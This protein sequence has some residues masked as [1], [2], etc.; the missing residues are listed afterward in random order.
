MHGSSALGKA[1]PAR[2][3]RAAVAI[4]FTL[5]ACFLAQEISFD[6]SNTLEKWWKDQ[7]RTGWTDPKVFH[8][9][10]FGRSLFALQVA[11]MEL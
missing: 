4:P 7:A 10:V 9:P 1:S 2:L 8:F 11:C 5:F 3:C 6:L